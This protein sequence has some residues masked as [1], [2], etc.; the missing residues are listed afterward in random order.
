M[1]S[2]TILT[3]ILTIA[4][5]VNITVQVTKNLIP[6]PSQLWTITVSV[7]AT[8]A[9]AFAASARGLIEISPVTVCESVAL[10][11]VISYVAMYGFDTFKNLWERF[12]NGENINKE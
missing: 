8:L 6:I 1:N 4:F 9:S 12:K 3:S 2:S 11:M 7:L 10:A 5:F